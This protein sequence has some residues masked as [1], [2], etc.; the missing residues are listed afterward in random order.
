LK[1]P[2]IHV[3]YHKAGS[4]WLQ[5]V[6]FDAESSGYVVPFS[7]KFD[8]YPRL[9]LPH[10]LDFDV[11]SNRR[12]FKWPEIVGTRV[13]VI[14]SEGLTGNPE[15]GG[16]NSVEIAQR[17]KDVFD[18]ARILIV[19]RE[20]RS[21]IL[22]SYNQYLK[23]AGHADLKTFLNQPVRPRGDPFFHLDYYQYDK[24]LRCYQGMFGTENVLALPLEHLIHDQKDF[25][26]RI[27]TFAGANP[28]PDL[29][30]TQ[31]MNESWPELG[32]AAKRY[33]N[34]FIFSTILNG[35]SPLR[36]K[37]L[38]RLQVMFPRY[39]NRFL[40][41]SL[42]ARIRRRWQRQIEEATRGFYAESNRATADLCGFE[43]ADMGYET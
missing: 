42:S 11:E 32:I 35:Y 30:E 3:G 34:P 37:G 9:V 24:I 2:L 7:R 19:F 6:L 10:A 36:I 38:W 27:A 23:G 26:R 5:R 39:F 22:S 40:R 14:T 28:T 17:L 1:R 18:D 33:L 21:M 16:Y 13:P 15:S 31:R 12:F 8:V 4:T 29:P 41:N 43:L 20:Q 25:V